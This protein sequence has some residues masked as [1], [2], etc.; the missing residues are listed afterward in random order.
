MVGRPYVHKDGKDILE[1]KIC[2]EVFGLMVRIYFEMGHMTVLWR[3]IVFS[4]LPFFKSM[5]EKT[6]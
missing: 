5:E 4:S 6:R 1:K 3:V 2:S